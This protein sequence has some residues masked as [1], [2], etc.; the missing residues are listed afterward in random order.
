M[1][2]S[3]AG[4]AGSQGKGA[5]SGRWPGTGSRLGVR[6]LRSEPAPGPSDPSARATNPG[7]WVSAHRSQRLRAASRVPTAA[8]LASLRLSPAGQQ[9]PGSQPV[10]TSQPDRRGT[11]RQVPPGH[12][13]W[14]A[15][16]GA[17]R[18]PG[19]GMRSRSGPGG[20]SLRPGW[21]WLHSLPATPGERQGRAGPERGGP[22]GRGWPG[23][24]AESGGPEDGAVGP[25]CGLGLAFGGRWWQL[26]AVGGRWKV[27]AVWARTRGRSHSP[28]RVV[29]LCRR[30]RPTATRAAGCQERGPRASC[31]DGAWAPAG[32]GGGV[33]VWGGSWEGRGSPGRA[34]SDGRGRPA[35]VSSEATCRPCT[36]S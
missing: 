5:G 22:G 20:C 33:C 10:P 6:W 31:I 13:L 3:T 15:W 1:A 8:F 7:A 32:E 19:P 17:G 27:W 14:S 21:R 26:V 24:G 12:V 11:R 9:P 23:G 30:R 28:D 25:P 34:E 16:R 35:G 18:G 4:P 2:R 36:I 29:Q